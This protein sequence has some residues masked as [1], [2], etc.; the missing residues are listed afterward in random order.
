MT[1]SRRLEVAWLPVAVVTALG[2]GLRWIGL[3]DQS[4]FVDETITAQLVAKPFGDMLAAVPDAESTPPLYYVLAWLWSRVAGVDET[5]LRSLSA[6]FGTL[7]IPVCYATGRVLVSHRVGV[8]AAAL[9]AVSPLLVWYS[10]EARAYSLF[11]LVGAL[12]LL[13]FS[14]A[15]TEPSARHLGLWAAASVLTIATH[16]FG[17]FLIAAEASILLY[18]NRS[19]DTWAAAAAIAAVGLAL[20]PLAAYQ[21]IHASSKWIRFVDL[22][23]RIEEAVRQLLVPGEPSIWAGAGVAEDQGGALWPLGIAM[24]AGAVGIILALGTGT[25][26]R[27]AL[28]A[29]GV[30]TAAAG[31]PVLLSVAAAIVTGGR[32]DVFLYRNVIVA[33]LPLTIVLAAA[34]G[35][36]RA[37]RIG[38][39]AASALAAWSFAVVV[40]NA[41]TPHLQRDDWR[42]IA[43]AL[44]TPGG[45][46]LLLSPSWQMAAL[47]YHVPDVQELGA[48]SATDEIDLLVRRE[49]PSYSPAAERISPPSG[50]EHVDT[51][52]LQNWV[53]TRFRAQER[54][55][56]RAAD[57]RV[58]PPGASFV[59]LVRE[60]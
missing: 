32:G 54:G 47:E 16:Y 3:D 14:H 15:L 57:L 27:G 49:V 8:I 29:L 35:A 46:I 43:G 4:F 42:L 36:R 40:H 45:Q 12:S 30:G 23:Q 28:V 20:L 26:R 10:Q 52:E 50:F 24:I 44:G 2:A 34:L 56:V 22:P 48:G 59:P 1:I 21:A 38:L 9:A 5:G 53:L 58:E 55:Y 33:W 13:Y 17:V 37:G 39:V 7:T 41:T 11:V 31:I 19:R 25:E 6:L 51:Q 18:R 60:K